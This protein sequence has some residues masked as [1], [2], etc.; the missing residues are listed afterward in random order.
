VETMRLFVF[1]S[2]IILFLLIFYYPLSS[3]IIIKNITYLE[4]CYFSKLDYEN[5]LNIQLD[6]SNSISI[7]AIYA[8]F[9]YG[10][11]VI[12]GQIYKSLAVIP[13]LVKCSNYVNRLNTYLPFTSCSYTIVDTN[14]DIK[15]SNYEYTRT[16]LEL[17][18]ISLWNKEV[19]ILY[20]GENRLLLRN[21]SFYY[22]NNL[23]QLSSSQIFSLKIE[24]E[25]P[26][27]QTCSIVTK[28]NK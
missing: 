14:K 8:L 22:N 27:N 7:Q 1:Q 10:Q 26:V 24:F 20:L 12:P 5:N 4:N 17:K 18:N 25:A 11:L 15:F 28:Q 3:T 21:C 23:Y 2:R 9:T 6:S 13:F 16:L 19:P